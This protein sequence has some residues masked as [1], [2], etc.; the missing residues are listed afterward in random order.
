MRNKLIKTL[1]LMLVLSLV[2]ILMSG[3][4]EG[5][6]TLS[7]YHA[8]S[9]AVPFEALEAE[10][11]ADNPYVDVLLESGGS[12]AMI[13]KAIVE[14]EAGEEPPDI[15]AS[16]DYALIPDRLYD[17]G[18]ADWTIIF[19]R[20]TMVLCYRDGA[21]FSD[22]IV[23]GARTWY[24][25]LRNEDVTW[26]H[27]NPDDDPCGY[28]SLM[29]FQLAQKYYYDDAEIFGLTPDPIADGLYNACIP[30]TD[31]ERGR[32]SEGKQL[33][34]SKSVDLVALLQSGDLDYAFEYSSVAVQHG[35]NYIELADAVNLAGTGEIDASGVNYADFYAEA[36]VELESSPGE[37]TT[38]TGT[39]VV[40]GITILED[41]P[42]RDSAVAFLEMLLS[43]TGIDIFEVQNGQPCI[44]PAQCDNK[45]NLPSALASLVVE[46][47]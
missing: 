44:T 11:E 1:P 34:R 20:N 12:A 25:V 41:A 2:L 45:E 3:C 46:M 36:Y 10:F 16:A 33:V 6:K 29:V 9:L 19:A 38:T 42:N 17:L 8:G 4:T 22:D 18:Y 15:I 23:G 5:E 13:N 31:E 27:S 14:I 28:R 35:L 26:G 7:V 47:Q 24:D 43:E 39:A 32:V 21:P 30:G 37:Y 40:Y